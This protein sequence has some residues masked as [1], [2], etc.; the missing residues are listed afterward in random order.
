MSSRPDP[1]VLLRL[2]GLL[3]PYRWRLALAA[4]ALLAA[5]GSVLLLGQGLRLVVDRGFMAAD[6]AALG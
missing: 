5:S 2:L 1:R 6:S 4:L 3:A